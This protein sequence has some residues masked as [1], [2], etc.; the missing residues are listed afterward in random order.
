MSIDFGRAMKDIFST[1]KKWMTILG[2]F[3]CVLIPVVGQMVAI[4]YMVR[5]FMRER[6]GKPA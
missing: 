2:L 6:E 3:V 1:E 4:G 5:R